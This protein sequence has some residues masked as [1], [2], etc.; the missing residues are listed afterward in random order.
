MLDTIWMSGA[1][2]AADESGNLIYATG[3]SDGNPG[4][5][6]TWT[7]TAPCSGT[8]TG[9]IPTKVGCS[10]IQESVVKLTGGLTEIT[11]LFSPTNPLAFSPDTLTMDQGDMDLGSGGVLLAPRRGNAFLAA[12]AG[13]D[14][15]LFLLNRSGTGLAFLQLRQLTG[16]F[17]APSY[18]TV[19]GGNIDAFHRTKPR[20]LHHG[21]VQRR[22]CIWELHK[23]ADYLGGFTSREWHTSLR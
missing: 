6:S 13:K 4:Q 16:C 8:A 23:Y 21:F 15:R 10:N 7:D 20:L 19:T 9:T 3:N 17:C 12:I 14:G 11:G 22:R 5:N 2:P 18:F 1:G